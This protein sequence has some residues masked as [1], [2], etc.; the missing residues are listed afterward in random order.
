MY[1][2]KLLVLL[3]T[4]LIFSCTACTSD[5]ERNEISKRESAEVLGYLEDKYDTNF[6]IIRDAS[7]YGEGGREPYY[8]VKC[9][10]DDV[11]FVVH[12]ETD[13]YIFMKHA[14]EIHDYMEEQVIDLT[15]GI[16]EIEFVKFR[17]LDKTI[18]NCYYKPSSE[19]STIEELAEQ[20]WSQGPVIVIRP[21][22]SNKSAFR[23]ALPEFS[24]VLPNQ[25]MTALVSE[26]GD[27]HYSLSYDTSSY[28]IKDEDDWLRDWYK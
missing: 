12:F 1:N 11:E 5:R 3:I 18:N 28:Y 13:S 16:D 10:D 7:G 20:V 27:S 9:T 24:K 6:E 8:I 14:D 2:N 17:D 21:A 15:S 19:N 4:I 26:H 23:Q 22:T 25:Y